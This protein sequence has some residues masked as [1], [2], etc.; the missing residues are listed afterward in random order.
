MTTD[1]LN[2]HTML[3]INAKPKDRVTVQIS[4]TC[5]PIDTTGLLDTITKENY[6]YHTYNFGP[7]LDASNYTYVYNLLTPGTDISY[8]I[9]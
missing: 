4:L 8:V 1:F 2:S 9:V 3:G 5:S 7:I 6:A